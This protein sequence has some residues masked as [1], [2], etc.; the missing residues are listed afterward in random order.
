MPPRRLDP[1]KYARQEKWYGS[2][3]ELA[4][5]VSLSPADAQLAAGLHALWESPRL[6]GPW[7]D[8][9]TAG[10]TV[11]LRLPPQDGGRTWYGILTVDEFGELPCN[12]R[13]VREADEMADWLDLSIP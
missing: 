5:E 4:I 12:A 13:I 6:Q 8:K 7:K 10:T 1:T 2:Y 3:Y 9:N 11:P